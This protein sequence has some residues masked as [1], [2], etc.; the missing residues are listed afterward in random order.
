MDGWMDR[1]LE[2]KKGNEILLSFSVGDLFLSEM[3]GRREREETRETRNEK[4]KLSVE[5]VCRVIIN[6]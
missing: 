3:E 2:E 6:D 5:S 1:C 4:E